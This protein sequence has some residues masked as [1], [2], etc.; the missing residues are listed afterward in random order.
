[1]CVCVYVSTSTKPA[2]FRSIERNNL[3]DILD[4]LMKCGAVIYISNK[5]KYLKTE[6]R[7]AK[8]VKINL[9]NIKSSFK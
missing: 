8:S 9:Y 1:M 3:K 5:S 6:V 7:Y 2:N 4:F